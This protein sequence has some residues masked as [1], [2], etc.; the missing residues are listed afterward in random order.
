MRQTDAV[1]LTLVMVLGVVLAVSEGISLLLLVPVLQ[2]LQGDLVDVS[3]WPIVGLVMSQASLPMVLALLV[4]VILVR[5]LVGIWR[6]RVTA[7]LRLQVLDTQRLAALDAALHARW[8]WLLSHRGSDIVQTVNTEVARIGFTVDIFARLT[9]GVFIVL[10][11]TVSAIIVTPAVGAL[12]AGLALLAALLLLPSAVTAHRMGRDQVA[13][14]RD[15]AA[16]VTDAVASLK[17]V[18]AH[19]SGQRWL[20]VLHSAMQRMADVQ[21]RYATR[22]SIQRAA[23][24]VVAAVGACLLVLLALGQGVGADQLIVLVVLVA[25]LL[26]TTQT[27]ATTAQQAA[28]NLPVV[29]TVQQLLDDAL[30]HADPATSTEPGRAIPSGPIALEVSAVSF[31]YPGHAPV[32][33]EVDLI[34]A[35]GQI[36]AVTGA[37]GVGKSTLV[38]LVLGLLTPQSGAILIGGVPSSPAVL[39]EFRSRLGYV[40]QDVHLL[41]GTLRENLTWSTPSPVSDAECQRALDQAC[42]NVT[43]DLPDGLDTLMGERGVRLSGGQR[44]RVALAR[45]LLRRPDILILDEA[46]SA[47]DPDT[48][49]RVLTSVQN[50][51]ITVLLVA[52]RESTLTHAAQVLRL[53]AAV[54]A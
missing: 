7:R 29:A 5:G 33:N 35:A 50:L 22:S 20:A 41:P 47:L 46:T 26:G 32:L 18:R 27:L 34:C 51:G 3:G 52:H 2:G 38:D 36:T 28:N 17:L 16:A 54:S 15:Y 23:V 8:S 12:A 37:S 44:Q 30:A 1:R 9:V 42:V 25:R 40:P 14:G 19:E 43:D 4:L 53:E 13:A 10:A 6:D 49:D 21:V 39:R 45:A 24:S 11:I 48:E 31:A